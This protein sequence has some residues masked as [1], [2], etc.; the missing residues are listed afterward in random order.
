[1]FASCFLCHPPAVF[2]CSHPCFLAAS[3]RCANYALVTPE[4]IAHRW[5]DHPRMLLS[6]AEGVSYRGNRCNK[7]SHARDVH[8]MYERSGSDPTSRSNNRTHSGKNGTRS[9]KGTIPFALEA[10]A[11]LTMSR[12]QEPAV[13]ETL[14]YAMAGVQSAVTR[15]PL[16]I[17]PFLAQSMSYRPSFFFFFWSPPKV[18]HWWWIRIDAFMPSIFAFHRAHRW[19]ALEFCCF[20]DLRRYRQLG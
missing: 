5:A 20:K 7:S 17:F 11:S 8:E 12:A 13:V 19:I 10:R 6:G 14:W 2:T 9:G 3:A 1:M 18:D 16:L 15:T 4:H